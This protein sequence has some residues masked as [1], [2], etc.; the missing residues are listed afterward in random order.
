MF[1]VFRG[2]LGWKSEK[3]EKLKIPHLE[4]SAV[5]SLSQGYFLFYEVIENLNGIN[6]LLLGT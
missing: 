6:C 1:C 5:S 4:A 2:D 3:L